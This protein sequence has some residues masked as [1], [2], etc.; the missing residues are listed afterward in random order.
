MRSNELQWLWMPALQQRFHFDWMESIHSLGSA[1]NST[2][3]VPAWIFVSNIKSSRTSRTVW[4]SKVQAGEERTC[5]TSK[6]TKMYNTL[7][8]E[9]VRTSFV[10]SPVARA[11]IG[12]D[13]KTTGV[14]TPVHLWKAQRNLYLEP[15]PKARPRKIFIVRVT[16]NLP[17]RVWRHLTWMNEHLSV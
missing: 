9:K 13:R 5:P 11:V 7:A 1:R 4:A 15:P 3:S 6:L 10:S 16:I 17:F 14:G 2:L 8:V 12:H